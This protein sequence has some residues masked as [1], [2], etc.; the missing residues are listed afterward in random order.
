MILP[1]LIKF[2]IAN[3][4]KTSMRYHNLPDLIKFEIANIG[5]TSM[6]YHNL[7]DLAKSETGRR[8]TSAT[9]I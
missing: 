7:P 3:I 8:H 2:E 5:K 6:R 9:S 1:V 4:G